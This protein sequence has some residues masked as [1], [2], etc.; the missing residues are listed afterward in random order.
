MLRLVTSHKPQ[1]VIVVLCD[2]HEARHVP[3]CCPVTAS[4]CPVT[5]RSNKGVCAVSHDRSLCT[6]S[7]QPGVASYNNSVGQKTASCSVH[8]KQKEKNPLCVICNKAKA[9]SA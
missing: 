1:N 2:Y 3:S 8:V 6:S 7:K 9:N 4:C 5:Q